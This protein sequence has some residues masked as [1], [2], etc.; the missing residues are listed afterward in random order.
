[1]EQALRKLATRFP[2]RISVILRYDDRI[3]RKIFAGSDIYLMPSR[4]EP[5]GLA[6]MMAMRYGSV[7]VVRRT[8]GLAD[9]VSETDAGGTGFLFDEAE[10]RALLKVARRAAGAFKDRRRWAWTRKR[11]MNCNNS[12]SARV[13]SYEEVYTRAVKARR[14]K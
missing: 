6:Q 7:P 10:P 8:G 4:F 13:G 3:A 5:C 11:S 9:T 14:G 2:G 12:W 1:M